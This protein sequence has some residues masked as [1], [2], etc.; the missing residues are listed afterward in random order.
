MLTSTLLQQVGNFDTTTIDQLRVALGGVDTLDA[1]GA[2][3]LKTFETRLTVSGTM[4]LTLAAPTVS[5]QRKRV[6]CQSAA[7]TPAATLTVS[8]PDDTAGFVCPAS[9]FFDTAGQAIEFIAT[10]ALKWRAIAKRRVGWKTLV[11]GTTTTTGIADMSMINLSVT[12][13]V[14][15]LTTKGIPNGAAIGELLLVGCG[16]A[17]STPHGDIAMTAVGTSG[18]AATALDDFTATTDHLLFMWTGAAWQLLMNNSTAV[19]LT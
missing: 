17:A 16:T 13:T 9:F 6:V 12:G 15:S 2:V 10:A 14:A 7:S 18:T 1:A 4:A 11:V 3:S 5:G 19:T 8:S